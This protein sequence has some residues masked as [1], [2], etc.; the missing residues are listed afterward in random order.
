VN[1]LGALKGCCR[2][3][4]LRGLTGAGGAG[5]L[6]ASRT[7]DATRA[8]EADATGRLFFHGAH[9]AVVV[10]TAA[11]IGVRRC[12]L[13]PRRGVA[14]ARAM[15]VGATSRVF[16]HGAKRAVVLPSAVRVGVATSQRE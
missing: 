2:L 6:A 13:S 12:G 15:E 7:R 3:A 11:S 4:R 1:R 14:G 10:P 8:K 5:A 9:R 16:F